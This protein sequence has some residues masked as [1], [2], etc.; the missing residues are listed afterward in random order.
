MKK[1]IIGLTTYGRNESHHIP[2]IHYDEYFHVPADYVDAIRRAGGVPVLLPPGETDWERWLDVVDGVVVSGG[3]D[4]TP[5]RYGGNVGHPQLTELDGE[6]DESEILLVQKFAAEKERPMLCICRGMQV[7]NVALG[8]SLYEHV[9][10]Q[11]AEDIHRGDDGGWA[12]QAVQVDEGSQ[13][14][15]VMGTAEVTTFSGHHQAVKEVAAEAEVAAHAPD[16]LI[17]ALTMKGHPWLLAVQWHPEKSAGEDVTQQRLF[18]GLV[19]EAGRKL[20]IVNSQSSTANEK[21]KD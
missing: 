20:S 7:F 4:I 21:L 16:G 2:S 12:M 15:E 6:R 3:A 11:W 5:S 10:D 19:Q 9:P 8:G 14:A 1:P 17:E 13:L 18:D